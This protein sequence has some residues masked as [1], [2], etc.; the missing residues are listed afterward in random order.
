MDLYSAMRVFVS[1]AQH[2]GFAPAA[3]LLGMSTSAVSRH[4]ADLEAHLATPLITRTTR[5]LSLTE[6]GERYLPRA[7]AILDDLSALDAELSDFAAAPTGRLRITSSPAFG[8]YFLAPIVAQF[9]RANPQ[10]KIEIDFG[11]RVVDVVA[12]GYDA[13]IRAGWLPDSSLKRRLLAHFHFVA[14]ASPEYLSSAP[15]LER[16]EDLIHHHCIRWLWRRTT[17]PW[18]FRDGDRKVEVVV[19]GRF[20]ASS[21]TAEREGARAGLGIALVSPEAVSADLERGRLV[22]VLPEFEPEPM[23][24][25]IVWPA[26]PSTPRKLRLFIDFLVE[27]LH[28]SPVTRLYDSSADAA[29]RHGRS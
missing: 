18:R 26:A 19:S 20:S 11:E 24:I 1:V 2:G 16:P 9:S 7:L 29:D 27:A 12:E 4:V 8:D 28:K 6:A 10:M 23:P 3:R 25:N 5:R 15:P 14:C 17:V 22:Q 13:A 21:T